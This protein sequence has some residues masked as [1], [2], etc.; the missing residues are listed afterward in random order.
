MQK[1]RDIEQKIGT[2][3]VYFRFSVEQGMQ[4]ERFDQTSDPS[5]ILTQTESYIEDP[6]THNKFKAFVQRTTDTLQTVTLDHLSTSDSAPI[7]DRLT[8]S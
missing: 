3:G 7:C 6:G 2:I 1:A 5:W 4:N 8:V